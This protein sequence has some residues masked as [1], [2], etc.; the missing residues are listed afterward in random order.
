MPAEAACYMSDDN[1]MTNSLLVSFFYSQD[2]IQG[3]WD[4]L[5]INGGQQKSN[6]SKIKAC[7]G[8]FIYISNERLLVT[9]SNINFVTLISHQTKLLIYEEFCEILILD[10]RWNHN[11]SGWMSPG[12]CLV[13]NELF[14]GDLEILHDIDFT[15]V[16]N[17]DCLSLMCIAYVMHK[18]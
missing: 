6:L 10:K 11:R 17:K 12:F 8:S 4:L 3:L 1:F 16:H 15:C 14:F 9:V 2:L 7:F 18:Y 5:L 13:Y